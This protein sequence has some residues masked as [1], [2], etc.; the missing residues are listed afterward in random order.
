MTNYSN[1]N[2]QDGSWVTHGRARQGEL[3]AHLATLF[4]KFAGYQTTISLSI[5]AGRVPTLPALFVAEP[6]SSR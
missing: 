5:S 1:T 4:T 2:L 6:R 3:L